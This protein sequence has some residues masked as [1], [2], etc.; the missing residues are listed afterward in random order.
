MGA[1]ISILD[2]I[3]S[4]KQRR[5]RL[6]FH[7][8]D[9]QVVAQYG[10]KQPAQSLSL[11]LKSRRIVGFGSNVKGQL[12]IGEEYVQSKLRHVHSTSFGDSRQDRTR[13]NRSR[14]R[15][16]SSNSNSDNLNDHQQQA[17]VH[18]VATGGFFTILITGGT[19]PTSSATR[20]QMFVAGENNYGQ[21]FADPEQVSKYTSFTEVSPLDHPWLLNSGVKA[22]GCGRNFTIVVTGD[23]RI[24]AVGR[25]HNN[26]LGLPVMPHYPTIYRCDSPTGD[27]TIDLVKVA[28][29]NDNA[30]VLT[31]DG[32]VMCAGGDLTDSAPVAGYGEWRWLQD[33]GP[34]SRK[35]ATNIVCG[36]KSCA[37]VVSHTEVYL[38]RL[39]TGYSNTFHS[40]FNASDVGST[41]VK[42]VT[43][44]GSEHTFAIL[45]HESDLYMYRD[46][47]IVRINYRQFGLPSF[48][49]RW[50]DA[51]E[52]HMVFVT[53]NKQVYVYGDD[54]FGQMG[55][56]KTTPSSMCG[57][58]TQ[59]NQE[60]SS[61]THMDIAHVSCGAHFTILVLDETNRH[62][63]KLWNCC[64]NNR[65]TD[66]TIITQR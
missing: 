3:E 64:L 65:L 11:H 8:Y 15:S 37:I 12:G 57:P 47:A 66:V 39:M 17:T 1:D 10:K 38:C 4:R 41:G 33:F 62:G 53:S 19:S 28:C 49:I 13:D 35:H 20:Q 36:Q 16:S 29:S 50:M 48:N 43:C 63:Q 40:V 55:E 46:G 24:V 22:I 27:G 5:Q 14:S 58:L 23:N 54:S 56:E 30:F 25:Y 9:Q 59:L 45:T 7:N 60:L 61:E 32:H 2:P 26:Q 44:G 51:G 6:F 18:L 31:R 52:Q 34:N 42:C 21:L